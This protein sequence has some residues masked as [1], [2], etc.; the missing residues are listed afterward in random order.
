MPRRKAEDFICLRTYT[1]ARNGDLYKHFNHGSVDSSS[2]HYKNMGYARS[3]FFSEHLTEA[4]RNWLGTVRHWYIHLKDDWTTE[5]KV[6]LLINKY[7]QARD[8]DNILL[9]LLLFG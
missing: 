9:G 1:V 5:P 8:P 4:Q 7:E 2:S 3:V 6:R